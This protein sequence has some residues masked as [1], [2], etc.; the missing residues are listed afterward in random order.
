[1]VWHEQKRSA[2]GFRRPDQKGRRE[3]RVGSA[4]I[5]GANT[6]V[7]DTA[8]LSEMI[9]SIAASTGE[10]SSAIAQ[11]NTV[12]GEM[13]RIT[14]QNAALVEESTAASSNLSNAAV[15]LLQMVQRFRVAGVH[16]GSRPGPRLVA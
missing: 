1:M 12:V 6:G 11:V 3:A 14:Q 15:N 9:T 8:R 13:E 10:Q 16:P 4:N 5:A 2:L 7:M